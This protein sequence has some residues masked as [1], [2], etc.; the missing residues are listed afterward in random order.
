MALASSM[1]EKRVPS[2]SI[3]TISPKGAVV[4]DHGLA[5]GMSHTPMKVR[6]WSPSSGVAADNRNRTQPR[7]HGGQFAKK[8]LRLFCRGQ[9]VSGV[10]ASH[11]LA[12]G[13]IGQ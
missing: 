13:R 6:P 8:S 1:V 5:F 12:N 11:R 4:G 7:N 2:V 9:A 10:S 3:A